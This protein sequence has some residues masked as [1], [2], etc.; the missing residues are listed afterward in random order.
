MFDHFSS[1]DIREAKN[2]LK[3]HYDIAGK[4]FC[5]KVASFNLILTAQCVDD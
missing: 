2:T 1:I 3:E 5:L 4:D